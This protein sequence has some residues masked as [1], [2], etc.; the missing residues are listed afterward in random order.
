VADTRKQL[1]MVETRTQWHGGDVASVADVEMMHSEP[2]QHR[3]TWQ[4]PTRKCEP[5]GC[6]VN[7][8]VKM[9][10]WR[11]VERRSK[12]KCVVVSGKKVEDCWPDSRH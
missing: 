10:K 11:D 6:V 2:K 8:L 1:E 4:D 3:M 5:S 7:E 9:P 12:G